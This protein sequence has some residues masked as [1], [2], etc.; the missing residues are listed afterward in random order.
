M[1]QNLIYA[2]KRRI[3][4]EV[5]AA[6]QN[7]P[8][9]NE[10]VLIYHKYPYQER[11]QYGVVLESS[12]ANMMRMSADNYMAELY[13]HV[14]LVRETTFPGL[15][16]EWAHENLLHV[17][18]Y[19]VNEDLST[20]VDPTQRLFTV[21]KQMVSGDGFTTYAN[22]PSQVV[23]M[24]N[25]VKASVS[26]VDGYRR[27][28]ML[29]RAPA[30][31]S[32][33]TVS[34]HY[35]EIATPGIYVIDWI[36]DT[37]FLIAPIYVV[38]NELVVASTTGLED[39][40][41]L[42]NVGSGVYQGSDLIQLSSQYGDQLFPLIRNT[43]YT[44]EY[45]NGRVTLLHSLTAGFKLI[46]SYRWQPDSSYVNGPYD[47][48]NYQ[49]NHELIPGVVFAVG[50]RAK[51]GDRQAIIVSQDQEPQAKIYGGHWTMSMD[52]SVIAKDPIQMGEM[53]DQLINWLWG[54]RKNVLEFEGVTLNRVEPSGESEDIHIESTGDMYYKTSVV[55]E[56]QT[57]WQELV[58]YM[59]EIKEV[60]PELTVY[61]LPTK[62]YVL[63]DKM[64][65]VAANLVPDTRKIMTHPILGY[66][67]VV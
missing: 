26:A 3:L 46:A 43:D 8:A 48:A 49:E 33:V 44:I 7:H 28:L 60:F 35:R 41:Q 14:R 61:A 31:G 59:Y 32:T 53:A 4:D 5:E 12:S 34:Y 55:V 6:Y 67:R 57:E 52:F 66:E 23:A 27:L 13:S 24:V 47:L 30:A 36:S 11:V 22:K 63:D 64:N 50:R 65:L 16:I 29:S 21:S 2:V 37:Q 15:A 25:G 38:K 51:T 58:P 9:F 42:Q 1:Y 40:V 45:S 19:Q 54:I 56:I 39:H 62:E 17:T 20:Q 18:G 10:K